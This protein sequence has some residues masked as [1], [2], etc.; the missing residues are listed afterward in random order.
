METDKLKQQDVIN[1]AKEFNLP[2]IIR[3]DEL[4]I[5]GELSLLIFKCEEKDICQLSQVI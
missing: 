5:C 3:E 4:T 2:C 1:L